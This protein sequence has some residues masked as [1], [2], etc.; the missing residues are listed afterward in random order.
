LLGRDWAVTA[1]AAPSE[2]VAVENR[3]PVFETSTLI[4]S[5]AVFEVTNE[6]AVSLPFIDTPAIFACG[7]GVAT[8][9]TTLDDIADEIA[10]SKGRGWSLFAEIGWSWGGTSGADI[11]GNGEG[12][13]TVGIFGLMLRTLTLFAG[14]CDILVTGTIVED[15]VPGR[16]PPFIEFIEVSSDCSA[17]GAPPEDG[18]CEYLTPEVPKP[19]L[20]NLAL[21]VCWLNKSWVVG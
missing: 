13:A 5:G 12:T 11:G 15:E 7:R 4:L 6:L 18:P 19:L 17:L 3:E 14:G 9:D 10:G 2:P 16:P 8:F 20:L 21:F 1:E